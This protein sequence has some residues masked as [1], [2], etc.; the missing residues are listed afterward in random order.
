MTQWNYLNGETTKIKKDIL[1]TILMFECDD[2]TKQIEGEQFEAYK[3][4]WWKFKGQPQKHELHNPPNRQL[5]YGEW[6]ETTLW[7]SHK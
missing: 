7:N 1:E 2:D 5:R 6:D 3:N 4:K